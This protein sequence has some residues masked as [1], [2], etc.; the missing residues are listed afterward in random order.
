MVTVFYN[1][2]EAALGASMLWT[3]LLLC[4]IVVPRSDQ[5][6]SPGKQFMGKK[7]AATPHLRGSAQLARFA[8]I[9]TGTRSTDVSLD[10]GND[11]SANSKAM[12]DSSCVH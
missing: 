10:A 5:V 4:A 1:F 2:T 12:I 7:G 8:G 6:L 9:F 3:I 11:L